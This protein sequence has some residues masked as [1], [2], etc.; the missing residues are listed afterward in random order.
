MRF[1]FDQNNKFYKRRLRRK[2]KNLQEII[3]KIPKRKVE[4]NSIKLH[5]IKKIKGK[6]LKFANFELPQD[7]IFLM[8]DITAN[9]SKGTYI[10][11]LAKDIGAKL[12]DISAMLYKLQRTGI[13]K[14]A[15]ETKS[16]KT[17]TSI[18]S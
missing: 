2:L 11:Q 6:D 1:T 12:G 8:L 13:G 16:T 14:I 5:N 18:N 17:K 15:I 9:V 7:N 4:I 3:I 10:R